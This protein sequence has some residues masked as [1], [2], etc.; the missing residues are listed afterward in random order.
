[1][2]NYN[3]LQKAVSD[4]S[5][6]AKFNVAGQFDW[7]CSSLLQFS[8]NSQTKW[9]RRRQE[10]RFTHEIEV[11]VIRLEDFI[12]EKRIEKVNYLHV[13]TQGSDLNVL[14]GLGEKIEIVVAGRIEAATKQDILYRGQNT[15]EECMEFLVSKGFSITKVKKNDRFN[16][17]INIYFSRK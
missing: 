17:E 5:G 13:D 1:L 9:G 14:R 10:F 4:F 15:K 2:L 8:E 3:I 12:K 6:T 11:E 7:G 16:N